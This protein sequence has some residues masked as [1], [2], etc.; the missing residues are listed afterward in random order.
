MVALIFSVG[1]LRWNLCGT[2]SVAF[3]PK[4]FHELDLIVTHYG[5]TIT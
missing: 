2:R 3:W 5:T 4:D 1:H